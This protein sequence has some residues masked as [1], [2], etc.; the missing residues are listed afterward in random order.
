M[1]TK[2][3]SGGQTGADRAALDFGIAHDIETGGWV[4]QGRVDED[5]PLGAKYST[6]HETSTPNY[7]QRTR[8]NIEDSDGTLIVS[9]GDLS[10]GSLLTRDLATSF[11]RPVIHI[12]FNA[13]TMEAAASNVKNWIAENDV[14]VLNVAGPRASGDPKICD[15]TRDLLTLLFD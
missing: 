3:M 15:A 7:T 2:I 12:D 14:Y 4:P 9:H 11:G 8:K 13:N 5:G 1:I 10:G 6:L